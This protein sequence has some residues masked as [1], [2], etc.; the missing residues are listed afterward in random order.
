MRLLRLYVVLL[1]LLSISHKG[2][3]NQIAIDTI[4]AFPEYALEAGKAQIMSF[5]YYSTG[6]MCTN[7]CILILSTPMELTIEVLDSV[8]SSTE[9]IGT[10]RMRMELSCLSQKLSPVTKGKKLTCKTYYAGRY[11]LVYAPRSSASTQSDLG[12]IDIGGGLPNATRYQVTL[13][14]TGTEIPTQSSYSEIQPA[15]TDGY[16]RL[17]LPGGTNA[18]GKFTPTSN[19]GS[20]GVKEITFYDDFG[21]DE[22]HAKVGFVSKDEN[23]LDCQEY[24]GWGRKERT[25]LPVPCPATEDV[26]LPVED[27]KR[28]AMSYYR[29]SE[30][31]SYDVYEPTPDGKVT[32]GYGPG[33]D[34]HANKR[35]VLTSY[36]TNVEGNDSLGCFQLSASVENQKITIKVDGESPTGTYFVT[37]TEDEDG[38]AVFEFK[39]MY[40]RLVLSRRMDKQDKT[41]EKHDTYYVYRDKD[42]VAAI[43]PP[44]LSDELSLVQS[45]DEASIDRYAYCYEYDAMGRQVAKKLP[46]A[47]WM[48]MYYDKADRLVLVQDGE[49]RRRHSFRFTIYDIFDRECLKGTCSEYSLGKFKDDY[50]ICRYTGNNAEYYGYAISGLDVSPTG[51]TSVDYYDQYYYLYDGMF[52]TA[53]SYLYVAEKGYAEKSEVS[54]TFHT[55]QVR[56]RL[57]DD[58]CMYSSF[59]YDS[60]GRLAQSHGLN[61]LG[62]YDH[63]YYS[64]NFAGQPLSVKTHYDGN[65]SE[66][67]DYAYDHAGR[68]LSDNLSLNG[69]ASVNLSSYGYDGLGRMYAKYHMDN[70]ELAMKW[71]YNIRSWVEYMCGSLFDET[72]VYNDA[73]SQLS[74]YTGNISRMSW[75]IPR[76]GKTYTYDFL[77]DGLSRLHEAISQGGD[78]LSTRYFYDKMGNVKRLL[79]EGLQDDD[80]YSLVDDL[81]MDY[82][83]SH[84]VRATDE[85]EGPYYK[86]AF[87]FVDG[88]DEKVE[89]AY[90]LN[91][92]MTK[93]MNKGIDTIRYSFLNQPMFIKFKAD[94]DVL[95]DTPLRI[96]YD[97]DSDGKKL[98]SCYPNDSLRID[99]VGN[100]VYE[101]GKL[102]QLLFDGGYV[103]F[104]NGSPN[105]Y[106]YIQDHLGN[107]RVVAHW[108]GAIEQ[109]NHYYPYGGLMG[110]S[111]GDEFQRY[112]YNGKELDR[113]HGLD[114]YDYGARMYDAALTRWTAMDPLCEKYPWATPYG[115]CE[116][117]PIKFIDLKGEK[118]SWYEAALISKHV[119]GDAVNLKGGWK[120]YGNI[121]KRKNG[122]QFGIYYRQLPKGKMDYVLA[123]AGTNDIKD[124]GLDVRQV[125]GCMDISQYGN[126]K[127]FGVKFA[128]AYSDGERTFVGHSLGGGLAAM[129][130]LSTGLP[131][132]TF[133]PAA[134]NDKT[135][136]LLDVDRN[137]NNQILNVVVRGEL[138]DKV[139]KN[140]GLSLEGVTKAISD[141][142]SEG[143]SSMR[144]HFIDTIVEIL[145]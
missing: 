110:I 32:E 95:S 111:K 50:V 26:Q 104:E 74:S 40:D 139:Q 3:A 39:D 102:R 96:L 131:A 114:W 8:M 122:L 20:Q 76:E 60:L 82:D 141:E 33:K 115:Y 79:R 37:R 66:V 128:N 126:A 98:S 61:H 45:L 12:K 124:I 116:G 109:V 59:Y 103:A 94:E 72:L 17:G 69:A 34:W 43:L 130:S 56:M 80:E 9:F 137:T 142:K 28:T 2:N 38:R 118:P 64:Y 5:T 47:D 127:E 71:T 123:F 6:L 22:A 68:L 113:M 1:M 134:L 65:Q 52:P 70:D 30:P 99:Y 19:D 67:H 144:K 48:T 18:V 107:N 101:N 54:K 75:D 63:T 27:V 119:Y 21:R 138:V 132:I 92:N 129:A 112:K 23:L 53:F 44:A 108:K 133:N 117:N 29:D 106:F 87:H 10:P 25:W 77:Y 143:M 100:R 46:G 7:R 135:K 97:Y 120:L 90:D 55:G 86:G 58:G 13:R 83:G 140:L 121:V 31:Y 57:G 89:Y 105:Y 93:D 49:R 73:N 125:L 145:K 91:G 41:T 84:L 11:E 15:S 4:K 42:R 81:T 62:N 35:S 24:D 78:R 85:V 51:I 88:A 14:I 36:F 136:K 16:A